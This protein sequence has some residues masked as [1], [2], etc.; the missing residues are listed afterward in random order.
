MF[1]QVH[2]LKQRQSISGEDL[3]CVFAGK[4]SEQDRDQT[5]YD[6]R[7][8]IAG[9]YEDRTVR[10]VWPHAGVEPDLARA[11][12]HLVGFIA[13]RLRKRRQLPAEL[14]KVAIAVV[15]IVQD[16]EIVDDFFDIRHRPAGSLVTLYIG[17]QRGEVDVSWLY[18]PL[19]SQ[20]GC[21]ASLRSC[22]PRQAGARSA[23]V[24][25]FCDAR[26][27]AALS[28]LAVPLASDPVS[29]GAIA[30]VSAS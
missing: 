1:A 28:R 9:K 16:G 10:A 2:S 22:G 19:Q 3:L 11:A 12:S 6:M 15:P 25:V 30:S 18:R 26:S 24:R 4:Y 20:A 23:G 17:R 7:V 8:A 5:A 21:L 13:R 14:D 27:S 29:R